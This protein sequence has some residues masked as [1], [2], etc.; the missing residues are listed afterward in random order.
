MS[1]AAF[2]RRAMAAGMP[3]ELAAEMAAVFEDSVAEIMAAVDARDEDRKRKQRERKQ[4]SRHNMSRDVSG[5][6][7]TLS[8]TKVSP[9]PP[10]KT[11][12]IQEA[13]S[14]PM[15]AHGSKF[16]EE[17]WEAYPRKVGKGSARTAF[18]RAKRKMNLEG[19]LSGLETC[20]TV[21]R[22][23]DP[24]FIPHPATWL[25][26]EGWLDEPEPSSVVIPIRE[27]TQAE[28]DAHD[29]KAREAGNRFAAEIARN[30]KLPFADRNGGGV[31]SGF[32]G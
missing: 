15:G 13:P 18:D 32:R 10:S 24:K 5:Q 29:V 7:V 9:T 12:P 2:L 3:P 11:Q 17:F 25:N 28:K 6:D 8:K 26:R 31:R 30:G 21:W 23:G 20:K 1:T 19:I 22:D 27:L 16:F 14:P 4:R